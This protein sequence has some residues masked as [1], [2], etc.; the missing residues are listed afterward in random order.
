MNKNHIKFCTFFSRRLTLLY[1]PR[2][3]SSAHQYLGDPRTDPSRNRQHRQFVSVRRP[4]LFNIT[5]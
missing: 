5:V 1:S 4:I 2:P 3:P